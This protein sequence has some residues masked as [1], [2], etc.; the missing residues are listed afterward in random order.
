MDE[1]RGQRSIRGLLKSNGEGSTKTEAM[2]KRERD[3]VERDR[4]PET[5]FLMTRWAVKERK[6]F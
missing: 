3:D 5:K 6:W 1:A 2:T 4:K